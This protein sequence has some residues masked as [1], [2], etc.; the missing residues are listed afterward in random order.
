AHAVLVGLIAQLGDALELLF[1]DQLGDLLD[2]PRLVDLVWNLG[3]GDRLAAVVG[4]FDLGLG[5]DAHAAAAGAVAGDDTG[6]AV[7]DARGREIRAGD[8][9]HQ[10]IDIDLGIVDQRNAGVDRLGEIVRRDVRRHA[11]RDA[12]RAVDQ[13]VREPGRHDRRL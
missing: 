13:Q 4:H 3:D 5:A 2:Q 6:G 9:F 8:V 12:G 11:D 1:L 7:D 10:A